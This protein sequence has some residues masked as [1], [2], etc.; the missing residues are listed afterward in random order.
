[1]AGDGGRRWP[2]PRRCHGGSRG[3]SHLGATRGRE[4]SGEQ[5]GRTRPAAL[6]WLCWRCRSARPSTAVSP[7]AASPGGAGPRALHLTRRPGSPCH[8]SEASCQRA[9]QPFGNSWSRSPHTETFITW[10]YHGASKAQ[11]LRTQLWGRGSTW[12][13]CCL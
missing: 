2:A 5:S 10:L 8:R 7:L 11:V 12:H 1:M 9:W 4:G 6:A 3:D 13:S